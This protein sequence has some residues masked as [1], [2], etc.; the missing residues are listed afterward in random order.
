MTPRRRAVA[1]SIVS[2]VTVW[3]ATSWL[4]LLPFAAFA[5]GFSIWAASVAPRD[6][7][8]ARTPL[9][10]A[11]LVSAALLLGHL[12]SLQLHLLAF[13]V[14]HLGVLAGAWTA[15]ETARREDRARWGEVA[16][17][18]MRRAVSS[19]VSADAPAAD[20]R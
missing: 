16:Q 20:V 4:F 3:P 12:T 17:E 5:A 10:C 13:W 8:R 14:L 18:R 7:D 2:A 6:P 9:G 11:I 19:R 15:L 1:L